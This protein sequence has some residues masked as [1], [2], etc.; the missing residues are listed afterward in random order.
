MSF[1]KE[2]IKE[3]DHIVWPTSEETRKYFVTVVSMIT[4]LTIFLFAVGTLLSVGLFAAKTQL[5]PVRTVSP[6]TSSAPASDLKLD[7]VKTTTPSASGSATP[8]K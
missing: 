7:S 6:T 2:S 5:V 3:F 4:I 1:I 8:T